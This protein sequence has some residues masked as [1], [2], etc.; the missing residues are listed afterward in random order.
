MKPQKGFALAWLCSTLLLSTLSVASAQQSIQRQPCTPLVS[1]LADSLI[2]SETENTAATESLKVQLAL[3]LNPDSPNLENLAG[4]VWPYDWEGMIVQRENI[5]NAPGQELL[6]ILYGE[7]SEM[8]VQLTLLEKSPAGWGRYDLLG[9]EEGIHNTL[10]LFGDVDLLDKLTTLGSPEETSHLPWMADLDGDSLQEILLHGTVPG[11]LGE[12]PSGPL[13]WPRIYRCKEEQLRD[14]S[15]EFPGFYRDKVLPLYEGIREDLQENW[16]QAGK[17]G[18]HPLI[19]EIDLL[20][21]E[22][23]LSDSSSYEE[24]DTLYTE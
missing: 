15:L 10:F 11:Y 23:A 8:S 4:G 16:K 20:R 6:I 24:S 3:S 1:Q 5:S 14:A 13:Y 17:L 9:S 7:A 18:H 12:D 2:A 21:R 22:S 19:E